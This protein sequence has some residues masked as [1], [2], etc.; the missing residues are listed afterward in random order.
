M[1]TASGDA[2]LKFWSVAKAGTARKYIPSFD[3]TEGAISSITAGD[4]TALTIGTSALR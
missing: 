4:E 3:R 2:T 1:L